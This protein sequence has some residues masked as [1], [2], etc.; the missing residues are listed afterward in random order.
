MVTN[1]HLTD[2][3]LWTTLHFWAA[4]QDDT[5]R[6]RHNRAVANSPLDRGPAES[7]DR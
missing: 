4:M 7:Q 2:E 1:L 5:E 3:F 6:H